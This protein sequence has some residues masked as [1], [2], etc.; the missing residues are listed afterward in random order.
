MWE[1]L[2]L[3]VGSKDGRLEADVSLAE[4]GEANR[5]EPAEI[6]K[7]CPV[8]VCHESWSFDGFLQ[9]PIPWLQL[10]YKNYWQIFAP[11]GN[12]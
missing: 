1:C 5:L 9:E 7:K 3:V 11:K 10:K 6:C 4:N 2:T 8:Y 12:L